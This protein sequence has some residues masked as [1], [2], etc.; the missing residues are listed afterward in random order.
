MLFNR[1]R[2]EVM[3]M[4][5]KPTRIQSR[6]E[7]VVIMLLK[8]VQAELMGVYFKSTRIQLRCEV[9]LMMLISPVGPELMDSNPLEFNYAVKLLL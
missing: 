4:Y 5:F 7:L 2:A 3:G 9:V 8:R 6:C 1:V